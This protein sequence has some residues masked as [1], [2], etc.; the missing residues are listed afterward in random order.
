MSTLSGSRTEANLE[1]ALLGESQA[2]RRYLYF[3]QCA[4]VEGYADVAALLRSV[5]DGETGHAFG[6]FAF[7]E[8][9]G[10]PVTG[11]PVGSTVENVRSAC[12]RR[13]RPR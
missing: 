1:A 11:L 13:R 4:D 3:A 12:R 5:A 2:N 9:S 7:L 8:Q 6:H 10:D